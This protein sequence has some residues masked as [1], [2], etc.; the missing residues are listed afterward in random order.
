MDV[1]AN[2]RTDAEGFQRMGEDQLL[3]VFWT[4]LFVVT[5][6]SHRGSGA[7]ALRLSFGQGNGLNF[8]PKPKPKR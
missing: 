2:S 8:N 5:D 1:Q 3:L 7:G 4:V 6:C